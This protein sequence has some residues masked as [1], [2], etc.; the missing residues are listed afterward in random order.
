MWFMHKDAK[1]GEIVPVTIL[2]HKPAGLDTNGAEALALLTKPR[3]LVLADHGNQRFLKRHLSNLK[4]VTPSRRTRGRPGG[5]FAG[6]PHRA[7]A[8]GRRHPRRAGIHC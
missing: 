5:V 6:L 4:M 1:L 7:Q 8:A 2:L 3:T